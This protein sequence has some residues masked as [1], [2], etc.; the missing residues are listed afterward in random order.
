VR[1]GTDVPILPF[2]KKKGN[3]PG[4]RS[5]EKEREKVGKV[6]SKR[7]KTMEKPGTSSP[8]I[9]EKKKRQRKNPPNLPNCSKKNSAK[10]SYK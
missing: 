5:Q 3:C 4:K 1:G 2:E 6:S 8:A 10:M 9:E 7:E